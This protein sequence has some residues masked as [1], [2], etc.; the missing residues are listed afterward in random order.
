[1]ITSTA[2]RT[3]E[4]AKIIAPDVSFESLEELYFPLDPQDRKRVGELL[5]LGEEPLCEQLKFDTENAWQRYAEKAYKA[6]AKIL[7]KSK[8]KNTLVVAHGNIINSLSLMLAVIGICVVLSLRLG[9][10]EKVAQAV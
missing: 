3:I 7:E 2:E 9:K 6:I 10:K 5:E 1:M 4:T 8:A